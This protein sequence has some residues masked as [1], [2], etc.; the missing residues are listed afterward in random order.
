MPTPPSLAE[1][2]DLTQQLDIDLTATLAGLIKQRTQSPVIRQSKEIDVIKLLDTRFPQGGDSIQQL[3]EQIT[4]ATE[5]YPRR[6]THPD[7]ATRSEHIEGL[8]NSILRIGR[9][10]V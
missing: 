5:Q 6:N 2:D 4:L 8:F 9:S 3:A 7:H 10:L 1:H